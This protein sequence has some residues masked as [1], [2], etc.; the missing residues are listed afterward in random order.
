[1]K[2]YGMWHLW[3]GLSEVPGK[4]RKRRKITKIMRRAERRKEK[5]N[6]K[7]DESCRST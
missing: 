5:I 1:M 7:S 2:A 3:R 6:V 4:W